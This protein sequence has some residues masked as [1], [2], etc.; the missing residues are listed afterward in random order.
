MVRIPAPKCAIQQNI[1]NQRSSLRNWITMRGEAWIKTAAGR[2]EIATAEGN[3]TICLSW[4]SC[5]PDRYPMSKSWGILSVEVNYNA[6]AHGHFVWVITAVADADKVLLTM[7]CNYIY[8][9][10]IITVNVDNMQ[11]KPVLFHQDI[12]RTRENFNLCNTHFRQSGRMLYWLMFHED[13]F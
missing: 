11:A 5:S 3:R 9:K 10:A 2:H 6:D 7:F 12:D 13:G 1:Y 8:F 4:L